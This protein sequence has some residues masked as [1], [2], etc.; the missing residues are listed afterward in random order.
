[1][2]THGLDDFF[3]ETE[4]T[5]SVYNASNWN[6]PR[7]LVDHGNLRRVAK[8]CASTRVAYKGEKEKIKSARQGFVEIFGNSA[9][10]D[11]GLGGELD[12]ESIDW[13]I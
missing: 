2:T 11:E 7:I 12:I 3:A 5:C 8:F 4:L 6:D 10:P 9:N 1:V 13:N